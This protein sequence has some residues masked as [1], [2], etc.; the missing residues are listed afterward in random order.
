MKD[1]FGALLLACGLLIAS[2]GGLCTGLVLLTGLAGG[3]GAAMAL[4]FG[5]V[6][7]VGAGLMAAGGALVRQASRERRGWHDDE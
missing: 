3:G 4:G 5:V 7:L 6:F 2:V 1:F